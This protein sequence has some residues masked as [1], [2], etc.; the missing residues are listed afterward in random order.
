MQGSSQVTNEVERAE[1]AR[2]AVRVFR[3]MLPTLNGYVR[4]LTG[5]KRLRIEISATSNGGTDGRTI[6]YR[7]PIGLGERINH[8]RAVCDKRDAMGQQQCLACRRREHILA[9]IYHE[10]AHNVYNSFAPVEP[11]DAAAFTSRAAALHG[12]KYGKA[13]AERLAAMPDRQKRTYPMLAQFLSQY[14]PMIFNALED[15]RVNARMFEA[16]KGTRAIF[17]AQIKETFELGVETFT[18]EREHWRDRP[19]NSQAIIGMFLKAS[20]YDYEGWL[21]DKVENDLNDPTLA[22]IADQVVAAKGP[23]DVYTLAFNTLARLRELG[24][25]KS[26][27]DPEEEEEEDEQPEQ[28]E[29]PAD[30]GEPEPD[31]ADADEPADEPEPGDEESA[32]PDDAPGDGDG[33]GE[34]SGE[35]GGEEDLGAAAEGDEGEGGGPEQP[36]SDDGRGDDQGPGVDPEESDSSPGG[37]DESPESDDPGEAAGEGEGEQSG[38]DDD[39]SSDE[40]DPGDA[41][42]D[43]PASDEAEAGAEGNG[44]DVDGQ[45]T[46]AGDDLGDSA[47]SEGGDDDASPPPDGDG[48]DGG[49]GQDSGDGPVAGGEGS[50]GELPD[51]ES[52]PEDGEAGSESGEAD[53]SDQQSDGVDSGGEEGSGSGSPDADGEEGADRSEGSGSLGTG[54]DTPDPSVADDPESV[55]GDGADDA[56]EGQPDEGDLTGDGDSRGEGG[57]SSGE[58]DAELPDDGEVG[59]GESGGT[60]PGEG[61]DSG[62]APDGGD[63]P[64]EVGDDGDPSADDFGGEPEEVPVEYDYGE[65]EQVARDVQHG[66]HHDSDGNVTGEDSPRT[67]ADHREAGKDGAAVGTA[68][69]Q[70]AYFDQSSAMVGGVREHTPDKIQRTSSLIA[71]AWDHRG[72]ESS[73]AREM[74]VAGD[75]DPPESA[76]GPAL[77]RMRVAFSNNRRAHDTLHLKSGKINAR[78]L[79]KRAWGDD[80]RLF[81][82][83]QRPGKRD[84]SVVIGMDVSGSSS[85]RA[86]RIEKRAVMAQAELLN[87]MGIRFAVVAH[88]ANYSGVQDDESLW[89]DVYHVKDFDQPWNE[90]ARDNLRGLGPDGG[91]LDGHTMEFY[92]KM[93]DREN[94]TDRIIMYYT[95]GAMPMSNYEEELE[96]L[97]RELRVCSQK[98]YTVMGVGIGTDS[99]SNHGLETVVV[100][101]DSD[102][103]AVV[104]FLE[105]RLE[106]TVR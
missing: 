93:L 43:D 96:V 106:R 78:A 67:Y 23:A 77:L 48:S 76:L 19:L 56:G 105:K 80:E 30:E 26:E 94:T 84:Y 8:D 88:S 55:D 15:A 34:E 28:Q 85:G 65:P 64:D 37:E 25:C 70:G 11:H 32:D 99:P 74:G 57:D 95:D 13:I 68:V 61:E 91:N 73:Y 63:G 52:A 17:D 35:E 16:R 81:K 79:G 12:S 39:S 100:N 46:S 7:P 53:A 83:K 24:Y 103:P 51:E 98:G 104:R 2:E 69:V 6:Q 27:R 10:I 36:D 38:P 49:Q 31:A 101:E 62:P 75:F 102:I 3:G 29:E 47:E 50:D 33:G 44:D 92:R 54:S 59:D 72:S 97:Q 22:E 86:I 9:T 87:R 42:A 40:P 4:A 18:G 90:A 71:T 45:S 5:N 1:K 20:G 60:L 41:P 66:T 82:R 89:M 58:G 21:L 14:L